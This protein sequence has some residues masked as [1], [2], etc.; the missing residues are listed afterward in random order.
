MPTPDI[1]PTAA[2]AAQLRWELQQL[3]ARYDSGAAAPAVYAI[4]REIETQLGWLK[5]RQP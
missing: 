3:R 1:L 4:I 5:H 2:N